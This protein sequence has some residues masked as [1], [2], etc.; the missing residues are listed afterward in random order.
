VLTT[1]FF[2]PIV[3]D[4]YDW[5]RIAA[6]NA[7]SDVYAMAG[8]PLLCLNLVAWP[9]EGLPFALLAR[10][11]DG[12]AD[13]A[14]GAGALVV[15]GHSIDDAEPKYGMAVVGTVHPDEVLAN[16]GARPGDRLVLTKPIGLGVISTGVKRGHADAIAL[17]DTAIRVMTTLNEGARDPG[18]AVGLGPDAA[19]HAGTDVT[20]FGLLGHLREVVAASGVGATVE[21]AAIPV[22]DGVRALIADGMVA[23]GTQRNHAFVSDSVDWGGLPLDEQHLLA[24]AQTSGGLLLACAPDAV[25]GLLAALRQRSSLAAAVVR[26]NTDDQA[27]RIRIA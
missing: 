3:D 5:G 14:R 2:T 1:D 7:L 20:G 6:S 27:G 19:V 8:T 25:D 26:T 24:D 18:R 16:R 13:V 15:G 22:I 10:V 17:Q 4:P 23:G 11:L 12:G 21:A 9:R